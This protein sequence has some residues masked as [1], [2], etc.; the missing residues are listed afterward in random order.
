MR[1]QIVEGLGIEDEKNRR[2]KEDEY[3]EEDEEEYKRGKEEENGIEE[4]KGLEGRGE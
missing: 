2:G 1:G 3:W 4:E